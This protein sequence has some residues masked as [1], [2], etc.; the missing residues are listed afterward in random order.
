[1]SIL[2][3]GKVKK[4]KV[5]MTQQPLQ[6]N[7]FVLRGEGLEI[8]YDEI[9]FA[10]PPQLTYQVLQGVASRTF[11]GNEL[12]SKESDIGTLVTVTLEVIPVS[13]KVLDV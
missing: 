9:T 12:S 3:N 11:S 10:G 1:V 5:T 6:A 7:R 2:E 4:E 8:I 13:C